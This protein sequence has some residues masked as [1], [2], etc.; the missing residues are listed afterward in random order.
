MDHQDNQPQIYPGS[1]FRTS[2]ALLQGVT[3]ALPIGL[4]DVAR[5]SNNED[6]DDGDAPGT[7][8]SLPSADHGSDTP[9]G[10]A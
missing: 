10:A 1:M 3:Q 6:Q 9:G 7:A 2:Q 5:F 4:P 8:L